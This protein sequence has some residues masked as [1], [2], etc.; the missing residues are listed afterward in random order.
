MSSARYFALVKDLPVEP[1][2]PKNE[3]LKKSLTRLVL[4]MENNQHQTSPRFI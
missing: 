3:T 4:G 2:S 1:S